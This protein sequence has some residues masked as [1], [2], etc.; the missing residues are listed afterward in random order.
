[1][2]SLLVT[3]L[4]SIVAWCAGCGEK[5]QPKPEIKTLR[6]GSA[7]GPPQTLFP[8]AVDSTVSMALLQLVYNGLLKMNEEMSLIPDLAESW[9]ISGDGLAYTF[10]LRPNVRFHDGTELTAADVA[11]TY[12]LMKETPSFRQTCFSTIDRI[13]L[14][15]KY[16]I[17]VILSQPYGISVTALIEPILPKHLLE[18]AD[19]TTSEF[20]HKPIGTGPFIVKEW[21]TD[22][23]IVLE[24]N[25]NY[26]E[27]G[28]A[29]R[30]TTHDA[31][32][33]TPNARLARI[34]ARG[35]ET[36][37]ELFTALMKDQTDLAFFLSQEQFGKVKDDDQ[38]SAYQFPYIMTYAMEYNLGH[39]LF[40]DKT[41]R[42]ALAHAINIPAMI[43]QIDGGYGAAST[44]PFIP[45]SWW[46]NPEVRPL[47]YDPARTQELLA[48]AGWELNERN[49][50]EKDGRE[51]RFKVLVNRELRTPKQLG[52]LLYQD[53]FPLG[54]RVELADFSPVDYAEGKVKL[55]EDAG[56]YLTYFYTMPDPAELKMY[57]DSRE[58]EPLRKLWPYENN[59]INNLFDLG[60]PTNQTSQRRPVYQ[61][62]H[63]I[64]YDDQPALF[65]YSFYNL[66]A[67]RN[68]FGNTDKLFTPAMPF[69]TIKDW[70][71]HHKDTKNTKEK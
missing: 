44:G 67:V 24:K 38:F 69:W 48:S 16:T 27:D 68:G 33:T 46:Y 41:V 30:P 15:D 51:F 47:E 11:F 6:L 18:H 23:T 19:M 25:T 61:Q 50:L 71:I 42:T 21:T 63:R 8:L 65:M 35:Y 5:P 14:P 12:K 22:N 4:L 29:S 70:N 54:I 64:L 26:Y 66:S 53:L 57:W 17:K 58:R 56:A 62:L 37:S 60:R 28:P 9:A 2:K 7:G 59:E 31:Q 43:K 10:H 36:S 13:E 40:T 52:M 3:C 39:P 34:E 45:Q 55:P 1:M 49:V 32:R 20:N